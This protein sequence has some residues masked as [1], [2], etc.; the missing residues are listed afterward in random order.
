MAAGI[1]K[2]GG[3]V[4]G[5]DCYTTSDVLGGSGLSSSAAFEVCMGAIFRGEYNDNDMKRFDQV[6]NAMI[7][8]YAENVFFG[9]PCGFDGPDRLRRGKG[10]HHRL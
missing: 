5:F 10:H 6:K 9:K 3:K 4:G 8:Q 1:V 2:D 7:S